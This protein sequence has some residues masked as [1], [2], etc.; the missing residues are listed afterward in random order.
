MSD[1]AITCRNAIA[2]YAH[3]CASSRSALGPRYYVLDQ[4]TIKLVAIDLA[5]FVDI[6]I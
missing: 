6:A 3:V 5:M 2:A 1:L 4:I